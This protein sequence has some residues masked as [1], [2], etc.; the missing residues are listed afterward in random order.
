MSAMSLGGALNFALLGLLLGLAVWPPT[1]PPSPPACRRRRAPER[2][3]GVGADV[4]SF[5]S[6]SEAA[7]GRRCCG[8]G[9]GATQHDDAAAARPR[10]RRVHGH[11]GV[12]RPSSLPPPAAGRGSVRPLGGGGEGAPDA[13]RLERHGARGRRRR[14]H[15]PC[16]RGA[17][18]NGRLR[19]GGAAQPRTSRARA[20]HVAEARRCQGRSTGGGE[21]RRAAAS[22]GGLGR[23]RATRPARRSLRDRTRRRPSANCSSV[24]VEAGRGGRGAKRRSASRRRRWSSYTPPPVVSPRVD[25]LPPGHPRPRHVRGRRRSRA[26]APRPPAR[27]ARRHLAR[28]LRRARAA[29]AIAGSHRLRSPRRRLP[30]ASARR[31][32]LPRARSSALATHARPAR[33]RAAPHPRREHVPLHPIPAREDGGEPRCA[34]WS[35]RT[36]TACAR[37]GGRRDCAGLPRGRTLR[38]AMARSV[39]RSSRGAEGE[40]RS[41]RRPSSPRRSGQDP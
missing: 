38:A 36:R 8:R 20:A 13:R 4:R 35:S 22:S 41:R 37:A 10:D 21:A 33:A 30:R 27:L 5:W 23:A 16:T 17:A 3:H 19:G 7:R 34:R 25:P 40:G 26:R 28:S 1:A 2:A 18:S 6:A 14:A 39:P 11:P 29:R 24:S 12:R 15:R 32:A 9:P 31:S